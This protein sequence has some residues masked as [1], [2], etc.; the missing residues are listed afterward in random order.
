MKDTITMKVCVL[1]ALQLGHISSFAPIGVQYG[2]GATK[3]TA[4]FGTMLFVLTGRL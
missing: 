2:R 1:L 4:R 3:E